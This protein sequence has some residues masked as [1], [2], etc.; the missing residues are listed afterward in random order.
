MSDLGD[1]IQ[2]FVGGLCKKVRRSMATEDHRDASRYLEVGR[3]KFNEKKYKEAEKY[4]Q[5]AVEADS[6]YAL[7]QYYLGLVLYKRDDSAGAV[8]RWTRAITLDKHSEVALKANA[9]LEQHKHRAN[10]S[11]DELRSRIKD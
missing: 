1:Q 9:K 10:K 7:A 2:S 8:R 5:K 11:I 4:F 6:H 3:K